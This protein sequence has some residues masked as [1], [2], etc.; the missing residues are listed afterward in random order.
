MS[1]LMD[2]IT[3]AYDALIGWLKLI[4]TSL[5]NVLF[6]LPILIF[7]K[8]MAFLTW[9]FSQFNSS[10]DCCISGVSN[11]AN[12]LQSKFDSLQ[13]LPLVGDAICF[14]FSHI[15]LDTAFACLTAGLTFRFSR[16][17]LTLGRW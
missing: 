1:W 12:S 13:S 16:K 7:E 5:K 6:D 15:G 10:L 3:A 4:F 2:G 9:G 11:V 14:F 8:L 17:L